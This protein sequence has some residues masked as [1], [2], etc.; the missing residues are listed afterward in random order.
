MIGREKECQALQQAW[1]NQESEFVAVYGRRRIGKTYLVKEHFADRFAF[2]HT[3]LARAD[4]K[5]QLAAFKKSLKAFGYVHKGQ[6]VT[7]Y[8]AFDALEDFLGRRSEKKK[9]VFLDEVPWMDSGRGNFISAL[10]HFW[11]G[12]ANYRKDILLV[13]C[14]S[15]TSWMI[16]KVIKDKGGL[17]NRVTRNVFLEPFTLHECEQFVIARGWPMTRMEMAETYMAIGGVPYYWTLL[18]RGSSV[19]QN[20]DALFFGRQAKLKDEFS[21]LYASLFRRPAAYLKIV[22]SL[23]TRKLGMTRGEL[24]EASG[25]PQNG[26]MTRMLEELEQ[27]GFIRKHSGYGR[28]FG[29]DVYQLIDA[30]TLFYFHFLAKPSN[31]DDDFWKTH[32]S[33]PEI[34]AWRGLAFERICLQH[35]REIKRKLGIEGVATQ[36]YSWQRRRGNNTRKGAQ[37]DLLIDR[38]DGVVNVCEMKFVRGLYELTEKDE[39]ALQTR[40][41]SFVQDTGCGKA[42]HLTMVTSRGLVDNDFA[43]S[44]AS[45]V[46]LDDLFG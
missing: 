26:R 30:Y 13:I 36:V 9:V 29:D 3:G 4:K 22:S 24:S 34:A 37:I 27:C 41:E 28:R 45:Q 31:R 21:Q 39:I 44:I 23:A 12:W 15:A 20:F 5:E 1:L 6:F 17:H 14:G 43:R 32:V 11:N 10:E 42:V 7:W 2:R 35:T 8:E 25:V 16:D 19:A 33:S 38:A 18:E 46:V 40:A